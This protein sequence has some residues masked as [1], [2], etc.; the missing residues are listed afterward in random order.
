MV[1]AGA[2]MFDKLEPEPHKGPA[3]QHCSSPI[4]KLNLKAFASLYKN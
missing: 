3:P 4:S 2:E 1:E